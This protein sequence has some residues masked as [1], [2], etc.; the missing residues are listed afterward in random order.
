[1]GSSKIRSTVS[2]RLVA[3]K[4]NKEMLP[5]VQSADHPK[6]P[7]HRKDSRRRDPAESGPAA[8]GSYQ[9]SRWDLALASGVPRP[10]ASRPRRSEFSR[11]S[12]ALDT[13]VS[14]AAR[15]MNDSCRAEPF[16]RF[17]FGGERV[18][19]RRARSWPRRNRSKRQMGI[20]A[21]ASVGCVGA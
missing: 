4:I 13:L 21:F 2:Q 19:G 5:A 10:P 16:E 11:S 14:S 15:S 7:A 20:K 8:L 12:D 17:A 9:T 1:M 3:I 18:G 6:R